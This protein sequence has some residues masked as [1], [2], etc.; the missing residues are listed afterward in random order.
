MSKLV[1]L[2]LCLSLAT[3]APSSPN[4]PNEQPQLRGGVAASVESYSGVGCY[5]DVLFKVRCEDDSM[6]DVEF[7]DDVDC[8]DTEGIASGLLDQYW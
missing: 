4:S 1:S 2:L 7:D 8:D 3:A 6:F 5:Q